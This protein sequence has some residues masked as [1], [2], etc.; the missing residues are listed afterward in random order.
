MEDGH[1]VLI[2]C[3]LRKS[4]EPFARTIVDLHERGVL[5][6]VLEATHGTLGNALA[7]GEEWLGAD[8][9]LLRCLKLGVAVHHGAL[10]TPYRREV[11]RLLR[12]G[13]LRVTVSSPTLAQGLNL[14]ASALVFHGVKRGREVI[15]PKE[16][17]NVVGRAGRAFVDVEGQVLFPVF[18]NRRN[19]RS[20][21]K[22]WRELVED[23]DSI[24][25]QSGL[26]LLVEYL[27]R[28]IVGRHTSW[29]VA[30]LR[31]Y[32][33]NGENWEFQPVGEEDESEERRWDEHLSSL[34][35]AILSVLKGEAEIADDEIE[36]R[37]DDILKSSLWERCLRKRSESYQSALMLG[38]AGRARVVFSGTT[39]SQRKA[40]FLAG[41]GLR[42]G[43]FLDE[44]SNQ[45]WEL[46][47]RANAAIATGKSTRR[48]VRY[49]SSP[50]WCSL[51]AHS[52]RIQC[53]QTGGRFWKLG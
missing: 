29:T 21:L 44:S 53:R 11:E 37:L 23:S 19:E 3:P 31:E 38:L 49:P 46:L 18:D 9:A 32:V 22:D 35:T 36:E 28:Q 10:P 2:Y 33:S 15:E 26:V 5:D 43:R 45:L 7:I 20:K 50:D 8:S 1:S 17:R 14:T 30:S 42:T 52:F 6:S 41:V 24:E 39:A 12:E 4:V 16:F 13:V 40:Y 34:D 25:M 51:S 27:L 47:V 48:S